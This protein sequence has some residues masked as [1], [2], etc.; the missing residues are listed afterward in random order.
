MKRRK[1]YKVLFRQWR[2]PRFQLKLNWK[3]RKGMS[4]RQLCKLFYFK[5]K[6]FTLIAGITR[7]RGGPRTCVFERKYIALRTC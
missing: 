7:G 2:N 3:K 4:G 1:G 6:L 5:K